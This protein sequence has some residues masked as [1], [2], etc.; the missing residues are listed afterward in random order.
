MHV[1]RS[2]FIKIHGF[3][4]LFLFFWSDM[5]L[6]LDLCISTTPYVD[7][8][9]FLRL[10]NIGGFLWKLGVEHNLTSDSVIEKHLDI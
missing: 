7:M 4:N 10:K 6:Q 2:L 9:V 8:W 1:H 5:C 3:F